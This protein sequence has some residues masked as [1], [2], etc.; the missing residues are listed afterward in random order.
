MNGL[1]RPRLHALFQEAVKTSGAD[2]RLGVTVDRV[3]EDG[4]HRGKVV[5]IGDAAHATS[6]H[7]GQG[8][9]WPW[10]TRSSS[11]TR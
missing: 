10:R 8:A 2:V 5:L 11:S 7:V 4:G 9:R 1:T 6:P 3:A